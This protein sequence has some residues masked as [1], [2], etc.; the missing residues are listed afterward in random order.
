MASQYENST[1]IHAKETIVLDKD[2]N[3]LYTETNQQEERNGAFRYRDFSGHFSKN[4]TIHLKGGTAI[5]AGAALIIALTMGTLFIGG[6]LSAVA[7][8][9]IVYRV[10][11]WIF[12]FFRV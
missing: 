8:T 12:S 11:N 9:W 3:A 6:I 1:L 2:G 7:V 5:L 4:K 10:F